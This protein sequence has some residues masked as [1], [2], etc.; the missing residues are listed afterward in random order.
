MTSDDID[1]KHDASALQKE[2]G[3]DDAFLHSQ[4]QTC[5]ACGSAGGMCSAGLAIGLR[6]WGCALS[7]LFEVHD[8]GVQSQVRQS[9][10]GNCS[11][12]FLVITSNLSPRIPFRPLHHDFRLHPRNRIRANIGKL[13]YC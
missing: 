2:R 10:G 13:V 12:S 3:D 11:V 8:Q 5:A 6:N 9:Q 7:Q 4:G 1:G